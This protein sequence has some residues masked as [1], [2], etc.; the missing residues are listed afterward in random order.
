MII[1]TK[2]RIKG[3]TYKV[4][5]FFILKVKLLFMNKLCKLKMGRI[6]YYEKGVFYGG[7]VR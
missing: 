4:H 2:M 1:Y 5:P 7:V 3:Y 6:F